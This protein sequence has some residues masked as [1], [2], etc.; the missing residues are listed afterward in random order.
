MHTFSFFVTFVCSVIFSLQVFSQSSP[1][2]HNFL[3]PLDIAPSLSANFGELRPNHFHSGLDFKTQQVEGKPIYAA[4]SGY[5]CRIQVR[6]YGYGLA[7]YIN[8][9]NGYTTV[10]GHIKSFNQRIDSLVNER[11]YKL[12]T[13]SLDITLEPH[14]LPVA[15][16]EIIA[17]SGNTG[18]SGGP[19]LH[20]EIRNTDTQIALNPLAFYPTITDRVRPKVFSLAAYPIDSTGYIASAKSKKF[21]KLSEPQSGNVY[22][23]T[24][25]IPA[26][27]AVGIGIRGNDYMQGTTHI[28]GFYDVK[29]SCNDTLI[30][31]RTI[32]EVSFATTQNINSLIDYEQH[33][34]SKQYYEKCFAEP[35]NDL[36]IYK[37]L[38]NK[39]ILQIDSKKDIACQYKVSDYHNNYALVNFTLAGTPPHDSIIAANRKAPAKHPYDSV[40]RYVTQGFSYTIPARTAFT[41][42]TVK[43]TIDSTGKGNQYYSPLYT[44]ESDQLI[45]KGEAEVRLATSIPANLHSKALIAHT[46][47]NGLR[48]AV[49][50]KID[51]YGIIHFTSKRPGKFIA[52]ID[53]VAPKVTPLFTNNADLSDYNTIRFKISDNFSGIK[54]YNVYIDGQWTI[55]Y[56]DAKTATV[57][58]D[59]KKSNMNTGTTHTIEIIVTDMCNNETNMKYSFYK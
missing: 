21:Y 34:A 36:E 48:A 39:G 9:A 57:I 52:T 6:P 7:L 46:Y 56:F 44:V 37:T 47:P 51:E 10:Y 54:D 8:H 23:L 30:Y 5:V 53:T 33:V 11:H 13:N 35:N 14:E 12:Q 40:M 2:T 27:G 18:S 31:H 16:G 32:D 3:L 58:I 24:Q 41:D 1:R 59:P 55:A 45:Y 20:F 28:Y 25:K 38:K 29:L 50:G 17:L 49:Q 43:I 26:W 22:N 19:H 4:D 42:F 15:R